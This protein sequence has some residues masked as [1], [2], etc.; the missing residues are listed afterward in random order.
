MNKKGY[1]KPVAEWMSFAPAQSLMDEAFVGADISAGQGKL[2]ATPGNSSYSLN[3]KD[4]A[5]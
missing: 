3:G 4:K 2:P 5:Y 1:Q